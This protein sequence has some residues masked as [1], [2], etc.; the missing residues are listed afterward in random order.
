MAVGLQMYNI[1]CPGTL[2]HVWPWPWNISENSQTNYSQTPHCFN[3][4]FKYFFS[5][6]LYTE[7]LS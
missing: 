5:S 1:Q 4:P 7:Y 2:S 3:I 6:W